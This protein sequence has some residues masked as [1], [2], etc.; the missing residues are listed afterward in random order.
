MGS[1]RKATLDNVRYIWID[2]CC[3]DKSSSAELSEA[4]NS[5][6]QWYAK[7][8][9]CYAYLTDVTADEEIDDEGSSFAKSRWFT[10]GWT[11]QELIASSP[12]KFYSRNW[13]KIGTKADFKRTVAEI[14]GVDIDVLD[15][16]DP[17]TASVAKRM[18]WASKRVTT[19][20]ED[21][22]YCLMGLF[23][24][25]MP[26]LYGEGEKAFI[27]LQ[28]E[29]MKIEDDHSLFAW[30]ATDY[31]DNDTEGEFRG[32]LAKSP[33]YFVG[34][35]N[36]VGIRNN[37]SRTPFFTTNQGLC[38]ELVLFSDSMLDSFETCSAVLDCVDAKGVDGPVAI[39]V[40]CLS[41]PKG[42]QFARVRPHTLHFVTSVM[43]ECK[44]NILPA[45]I[46]YIRQK[47]EVLHLQIRAYFQYINYIFQRSHRQQ[48]S[49]SPAPTHSTGGTIET[50]LSI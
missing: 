46:L 21:I 8:C 41:P 29:I 7:A 25:N 49:I 45:K 34:S 40:Q 19:R 24:V 37:D 2:T 42:V 18:S 16:Q 14:T 50:E 30:R 31:S 26:L 33:A 9:V 44:G 28:E 17:Q 32:L 48:D 22:A 1:C 47:P 39:Q 43:R 10:R 12:L 20:V 6:Y 38:I 35:Q 27:R 3:I 36:F 11:L 23:G 13:K 5:M 15:G 4:I